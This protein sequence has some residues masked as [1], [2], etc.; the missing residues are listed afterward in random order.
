M[1]HDFLGIVDVGKFQLLLPT[2]K[3][4]SYRRLTTLPRQTNQPPQLHELDLSEH[5]GQTLMVKG[6]EGGEWLWSAEIIDEAGPILTAIVQKLYQDTL[7][8]GE[9]WH[10]NPE[11]D[12]QFWH[13]ETS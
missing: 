2:T 9:H 4:G 3:G 6:E 1:N 5:E 8:R 7:Q 10:L 11:T 12:S 13:L